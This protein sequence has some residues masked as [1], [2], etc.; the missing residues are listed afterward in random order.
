MERMEDQAILEI[1]FKYN[2][3]GKRKLGRPQNR[4]KDHFII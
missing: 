4:W 2:P 1:I 3:V